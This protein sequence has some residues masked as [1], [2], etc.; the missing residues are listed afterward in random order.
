MAGPAAAG[1]AS[2]LSKVLSDGQSISPP[3]EVVG[4][5]VLNEC[6]TLAEAKSTAKSVFLIAN[7]VTTSKALVTTSKAPV[8][9]SDALV[10]SSEPCYY[11]GQLTETQMLVLL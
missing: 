8:T 2:L 10:P 7:I 3:Q 5:T 4:A 6:S 9:R 1:L 11:H